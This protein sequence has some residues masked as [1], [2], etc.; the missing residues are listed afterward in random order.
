MKIFYLFYYD[1]KRWLR[2][3]TEFF[4]E[5]FYLFRTIVSGN[6]VIFK[7]SENVWNEKTDAKKTSLKEFHEVLTIPFNKNEHYLL[8]AVIGFT[9]VG[10][11]RNSHALARFYDKGSEDTHS[12]STDRHYVT[13]LRTENSSSWTVIDDVRTSE[14]TVRSNHK[15]S[16]RLLT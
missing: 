8:V 1:C 9:G 12:M 6:V 16:P 15:I 3:L 5:C 11:T 13:Y 7:I 14:Y 10:G 2:S 4:R